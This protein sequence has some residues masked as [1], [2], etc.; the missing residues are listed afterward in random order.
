MTFASHSVH[1]FVILRAI[2]FAASLSHE[3]ALIG[4]PLTRETFFGRVVPRKYKGN[5]N[6]Q[7]YLANTS[8]YKREVHDLDNENRNC[9]VDEIIRATQDK[10]FGSLHEARRD[11]FA[12]CPFC[13]SL[14]DNSASADDAGS[15]ALEGITSRRVTKSLSRER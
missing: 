15:N 4:R 8:P 11:E 7:R 13:C 2:F 1:K 10:P 6:G 12:E 5:M 14:V 3:S 9:M